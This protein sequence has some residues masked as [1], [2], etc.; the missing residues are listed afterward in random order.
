[1][2]NSPLHAPAPVPDVA[3]IALGSNLG[4][5]EQYIREARERIGQIPG[6]KILRMTEI[7]ETD[8][9]GGLD[10]PAFYNQMIAIRTELNP[11]ELLSHLHAVE[12]AGSRE[13]KTRW[14]SRTIDLDIV[15]YANT[16]WDE[17]DLHVP[18]T[19][20]PNRDFW[21]RELSELT[22]RSEDSPV[23]SSEAP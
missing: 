16:T 2:P 20:L 15:S 5:R 4:D 23:D 21:L 13:R 19:E 9:L 6:V 14:G 7:E 22:A 10:Q 1:M 12:R 3:Y 11:R 18:H 17:P 8:P